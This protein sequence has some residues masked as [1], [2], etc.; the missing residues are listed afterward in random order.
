MK[1]VKAAVFFLTHGAVPVGTATR[2]F[3]DSLRNPAAQERYAK[4]AHGE[5]KE[6]HKVYFA[7]LLVFSTGH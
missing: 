3:T 1:A 2:L 6:W 7:F 4:S 5:E